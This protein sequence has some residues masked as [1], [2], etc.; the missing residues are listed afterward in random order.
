M[1]NTRRVRYC[2]VVTWVM[3]GARIH[4]GKPMARLHANPLA[5]CQDAC[6]SV[7]RR[8]AKYTKCIII[9]IYI[10]IIG[11]NIIKDNR[12]DSAICAVLRNLLH[13]FSKKM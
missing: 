5:H 4:S 11:N 9:N 6:D 10:S 3:D 1:V 2:N 12:R 7:A 13:A 8:C